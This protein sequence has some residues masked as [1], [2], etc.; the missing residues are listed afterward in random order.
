MSGLVQVVVYPPSP[1]GGRRVRADGEILG[2]ARSARDVAELVR[3]AG[4]TGV[5]EANVGEA[6]AVE[7]W[8][9]P[10]GP[11]EGGA[12]HSPLS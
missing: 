2:L 6:G 10:E 3:R 4:M 7:A 8:P 1:S 12:A 5:T 9:A 11:P